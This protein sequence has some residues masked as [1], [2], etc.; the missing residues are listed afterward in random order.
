MVRITGHL[1]TSVSKL[2]GVG[3]GSIIGWNGMLLTKSWR[4][5]GG[6]YRVTEGRYR[7]GCCTTLDLWDRT[8]DMVDR[9]FER[10]RHYGVSR[11]PQRQPPVPGFTVL[12]DG[13]PLFEGK[14]QLGFFPFTTRRLSSYGNKVRTRREVEVNKWSVMVTSGIDKYVI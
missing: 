12:Q 6:E 4:K 14:E 5:D 8:E 11:L 7:F 9:T 10:S 2:R 13:V 1:L 3:I